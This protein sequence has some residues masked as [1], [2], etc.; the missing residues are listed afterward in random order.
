VTKR[1]AET[2]SETQMLLF[3]MA[4]VRDWLD[5]AQRERDRYLAATGRADKTDSAL[6]L[7]ITLSHVE[8]WVYRLHVEGNIL[9]W[10]ELQTSGKWDAWV[11]QNCPAMLLL[12]DLCNAAKHRVLHS[13][14]TRTAKAE[15]GPVVYVIE[16]LR[17]ADEFIDRVR[18]FSIILNVRTH[19]ED[20]EIAY[21]EV[22]TQVHKLIGPDGFRL[23]IDICNDA[24]RFWGEF[25]EVRGL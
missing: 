15:I 8:D 13:R 20:D 24:I 4:T 21:F 6:N 16:D 5:K 10:P 9:D 25:L 3:G 19:N 22:I 17:Y 7:A 1:Q 14:G 11:R 12:A 23:F 18:K 2:P